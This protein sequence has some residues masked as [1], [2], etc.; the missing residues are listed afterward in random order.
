[1]CVL[2]SDL[3]MGVASAVVVACGAK[4][5]HGLIAHGSH[6]VDGHLVLNE[7]WETRGHYDRFVEERLQTTIVETIGDRARPPEI[8]ER[9]LHSYTIRRT[10]TC[11]YVCA[12]IAVDGAILSACSVRVRVSGACLGSYGAQSFVRSVRGRRF[13]RD[14]A[15]LPLAAGRSD[16]LRRAETERSVRG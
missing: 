13:S 1:M 8:M 14:P 15:H 10:R 9:E 6:E 3:A 16:Q 12:W 4:V 2:M 11:R 5:G 7:V